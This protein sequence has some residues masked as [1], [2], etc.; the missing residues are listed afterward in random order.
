MLQS[1]HDEKFS[2]E[3]I[4]RDNSFPKKDQPIFKTISTTR[5]FLLKENEYYDGVL[6][7]KKIQPPTEPDRKTSSDNF[8]SHTSAM[9]Q[10]RGKRDENEIMPQSK[11]DKHLSEDKNT[12]D[13]IENENIQPKE[14]QQFLKTISET[15][16]FL[17][18]ENEHYDGITYKRRTRLLSIRI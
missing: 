18:A 17:S 4:E 2:F 12:S 9:R 5:D 10:S 16:D 15:K 14:E 6:F 1:K 11:H 13:N 3:N 7:T 8:I